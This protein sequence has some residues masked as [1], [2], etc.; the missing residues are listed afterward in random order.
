[1]PFNEEL[2]NRVREMLAG[3]QRVTEQ[4]M[5]GGIAFLLDSNMC[6]G[7]H[8]DDLIVRLAK[9]DEDDPLADPNVRLMDIGARSMKGW[10]FVSPE[11]TRTER[12]LR[13]WVGRAADFAGSLPAKRTGQ[14]RG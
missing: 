7:V 11:G 9:D 2:A 4:K 12:D 8:R 1:M 5:F 6:C 13:R 14:R 3:R 10:Y